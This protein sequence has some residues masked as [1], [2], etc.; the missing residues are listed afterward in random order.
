MKAIARLMVRLYPNEWQSR[1]GD[2]MKATID[3][4]HVTWKTLFDLVS[5]ATLA[6]LFWERRG[7]WRTQ[8]LA[9]TT[10]L[11]FLCLF[12]YIGVQQWMRQGAN[13]PQAT[14]VSKLT[15]ALSSGHSI[16]PLRFTHVV[17]VEHSLTPFVIVYNQAGMPIASTVHLRGRTPRLPVGVLD[18]TRR[19]GRDVVTWQ[20]QPDA[21]IAA[22]I[23]P[24]SG[25]FVLAGRA[26][27]VVEAQETF[28]LNLAAM[29]WAALVAAFSILLG[30]VRMRHRPR[31]GS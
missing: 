5:R 17:N 22:V 31:V 1:Y 14:M 11:T 15:T 27:R 23:E 18:Y 20:P 6:H 29:S 8:F 7:L 12:S 24:Y 26:L 19:H 3:Q 4:H 16:T 28:A 30:Y 2:E 9:G 10:V 13:Q 25:G 21:R